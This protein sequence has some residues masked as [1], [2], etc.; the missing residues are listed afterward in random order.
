MLHILLLANAVG[1]LQA[2]LGKQVNVQGVTM[3]GREDASGWVKKYQVAYSLDENNWH[4]VKL[5]GVVIEVG[6]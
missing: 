6:S 4:Y 5:D 1:V 2:D 3:Q